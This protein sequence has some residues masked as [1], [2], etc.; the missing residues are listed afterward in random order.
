[1]VNVAIMSMES[2]FF[3]SVSAILLDPDGDPLS[4][5]VKSPMQ[6]R[7]E[8]NKRCNNGESIE[9]KRR[10]SIYF[11]ATPLFMLVRKALFDL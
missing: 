4:G 8:K 11:E 2:F 10:K 5:F 9:A 7:T 6:G 1:M 3:S